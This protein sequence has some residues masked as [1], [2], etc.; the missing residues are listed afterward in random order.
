MRRLILFRHGKREINWCDRPDDGPLV[1]EHTEEIIRSARDLATELYEEGIDT[2]DYVSVSGS[3]R[4]A[5]T[6]AH[7]WRTLQMSGIQVAEYDMSEEFFGIDKED[8]LM[9]QMYREKRKE[10]ESLRATEGEVEAYC[11]LVPGVVFSRAKRTVQTLRKALEYKL[12]VMAVTYSPCEAIIE[13]MFLNSKRRRDP[14]P[15]GTYS[16]ITVP[17]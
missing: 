7:V 11:K 9:R 6:F 14:I 17:G 10:F 3:I 1:I 12:T 15:Q 16:L 13:G 8:R 5:E 2:I 4:C